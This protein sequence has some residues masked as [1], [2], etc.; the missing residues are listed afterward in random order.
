MSKTQGLERIGK[1]MVRHHAEKQAT[2]KGRSLVAETTSE[3]RA[4]SEKQRE[5]RA[6]NAVAELLMR[7]LLVPKIFLE[8][9]HLEIPVKRSLVWDLDRLLNVLAI[10]KAGSGDIHAVKV[11]L[12]KTRE[13]NDE[14][15]LGLC[16]KNFRDAYPV[17][18]KY[19][20]VDSE[21][22]DFVS[23]LQLFAENGIGRVGIIEILENPGVAPEARIVI[24]P[25]RFRVAPEWVEKFDKFQQKTP[26]D[27]EIRG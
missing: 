23:K 9:R 10:D 19:I 11:I 12:G 16:T 15:K 8:P 21:A 1:R 13:S 20:A 27:M 2:S 17:H 3:A 14:I 5:G 22:V 7:K 6:V 24:Q 25:E 4:I 18:F 26:A